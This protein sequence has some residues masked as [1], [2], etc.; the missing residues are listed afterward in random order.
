MK[1]K[2]FILFCFTF[3]LCNSQNW[4]HVGNG[5]NNGNNGGVQIFEFNNKL[6]AGGNFNIIDNKSTS[7]IAYWN[8]IN[9]IPYSSLI[10]N[11]IGAFS[12]YKGKLYG[13]S[14]SLNST[15]F[16]RLVMYNED[17][18]DWSVV[19]SSEIKK[20]LGNGN[21]VSGYIRSALEFRNELYVIGDFDFIGS[22]QIKNF[23]KWDG[24]LWSPVLGNDSL[25][26]QLDNL[27]GLIVFQDELIINGRF[28]SLSGEVYNDIAQWDGNKWSNLNNGLIDN[29]PGIG[30]HISDLEIY[31]GELYAGGYGSKIN[32]EG[33]GFLVTKW[34]GEYWEGVVGFE[35]DESNF[36][37]SRVTALKSFGN[38]LIAAV[39]ING[40]SLLYNGNNIL[41][42]EDEL[43]HTITNFDILNNQLY[44]GGYFHGDGIPNGIARLGSLTINEPSKLVCSLFPN[45]TSGT[46]LLEYQLNSNSGTVIRIYNIAGKLLFHKFSNDTAG[47]YLRE[48]DMS[49]FPKG[50]YILNIHT[51]EFDETKKVILN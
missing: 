28:D 36:N 20:L 24:I 12:T 13:F 30:G 47:N 46:L 37:Y 27:T 17:N 32:E 14:K 26:I 18:N 40:Q 43:N 48:I 22:N 41:K 11:S 1:V 5:T 7:G 4:L 38:F 44:A 35:Q 45:P 39:G 23:A 29:T 51:K 31:K 9:W 15:T 10:F 6:F 19:T 8:D 33:I 49:K 2:L 42:L 34:N 50:S 16:S 3:H 21:I 25:E